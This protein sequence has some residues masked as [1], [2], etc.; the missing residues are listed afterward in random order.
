M[1]TG[2]DD[3]FKSCVNDVCYGRTAPIRVGG[4]GNDDI[5]LHG[6]SVFC[7]ITTQNQLKETSLSSCKI[8]NANIDLSGHINLDDEGFVYSCRSTDSV[9]RT[10]HTYLQ[11]DSFTCTRLVER[12]AY[13]RNSPKPSE[14][15]NVSKSPEPKVSTVTINENTI[16]SP[17][18]PPSPNIDPFS[19]EIPEVKVNAERISSNKEQIDQNTQIIQ[20]TSKKISEYI[21]KQNKA[22]LPRFGF[23]RM[24]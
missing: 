2:S 3:F 8:D 21:S 22:P 11:S 10:N 23:A 19:S 12:D 4:N 5:T 16:I 20:E 17:A 18:P 7:P 14:T 6:M 24:E 1:A 13:E 15:P 9:N